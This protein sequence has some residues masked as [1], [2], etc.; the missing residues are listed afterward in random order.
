MIVKLVNTIKFIIKVISCG[1][2]C[3]LTVIVAMQ[4]INRNFFDHSFTWVEELAGISMIFVTYLGAAIAT[5]NNSNTRI[6]FFIRMLPQKVTDAI[7]LLDN[8][9]CVAFLG[10]LSKLSVQLMKTNINTLTPA[11][12]LPISINYFGILIGCV[13]MILFYL[14]HACLDIQKLSGKNIDKIEEALNP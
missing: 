11:M 3:M 7:N 6:D 10:V 13:L 1:M 2:I 9:I 4:V 14:L 5:V 12:K 8:L